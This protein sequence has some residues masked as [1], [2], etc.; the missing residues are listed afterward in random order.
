MTTVAAPKR[1]MSFACWMKFSSPSFNEIELT[2]PFPWIHFRPAT[3]ISH[4]ELSI[5]I[6]TRAISGSEA[7]RFK[8]FTIASFP[9]IIPSSML[10]SMI[11]APP[12]TCSFATESAAS[13]S[14]SL[15]MRKNAREPVTLVRSPIFVKL[16]SGVMVMAS[17]PDN[18]K[19]LISINLLVKVLVGNFLQFLPCVGCDRVK[20]HNNLQ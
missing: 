18:R 2:I 10:M 17:S 3:M 7:M 20:Y 12:S 8:N 13:K 16:L 11:C 19:K 4:L 9:S 1:L 14:F 15:I 5:I 6:G